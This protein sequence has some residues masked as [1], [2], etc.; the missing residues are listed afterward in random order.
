[1]S[2]TLRTKGAGPAV[3]AALMALAGLLLTFAVLRDDTAGFDHVTLS[4][5][6]ALRGPA[7]DG[8]FLVVTW[9]G[10]SYVLVPM[11]LLLMAA[12]ATSRQWPAACGLGLTYFGASLTTWLLKAAFGR[13]RPILHAWVEMS[14][15]DASFPS[16]HATHAAAF[17][18]ALWLFATR[19]G[20]PRW[21]A[22]AAVV[23]TTIVMAVAASRLYLQVHWPSDVL[24]GF[25]VAAVWA[26][27]ALATVGRGG[28]VGRAV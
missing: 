10:S 16:G 12:L 26:G 24:A 4:A 6:A 25:L 5:F 17:A 8:F 2:P 3:S 15:A 7:P 18:L 1:M 22:P 14:P 19:H 27:L 20:W 9:L 28:S 21:R 13:E 23:L 11:T